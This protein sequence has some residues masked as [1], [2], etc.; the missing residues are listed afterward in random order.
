[1]LEDRL[2]SL[3][4]IQRELDDAVTLVELGEMEGDADD[5]DRR[6]SSNCKA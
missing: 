3:A 5:R 2:G 6:A 4:K 1:M